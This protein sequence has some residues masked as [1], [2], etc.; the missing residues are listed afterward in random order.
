MTYLFAQDQFG[1]RRPRAYTLQLPRQPALVRF[2]SLLF[3]LYQSLAVFTSSSLVLLRL[4]SL[5]PRHNSYYPLFPPASAVPL[6][7]GHAFAAPAERPDA[8]LGPLDMAVAPDL[9][10]VPSQLRVAV[11]AVGRTLCINPGRL[12]TGSSGGTY[13]RVTVPARAAGA[14]REEAAARVRVDIVQI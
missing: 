3:V 12:T 5:H 14:G 1:A 8:R 13:A 11:K 10:I 4:S 9:L 6:D 2:F 7:V